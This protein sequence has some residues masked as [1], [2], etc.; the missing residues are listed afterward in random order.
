MRREDSA[1]GT[2]TSA[3]PVHCA[4]RHDSA[5]IHELTNCVPSKR[6]RTD[7]SRCRMYASVVALYCH[8]REVDRTMGSN[9]RAT[10]EDIDSAAFVA[11]RNVLECRMSLV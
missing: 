3:V 5:L 4:E 8:S 2:G 10:F 11:R 7:A 1:R 9:L 6:T